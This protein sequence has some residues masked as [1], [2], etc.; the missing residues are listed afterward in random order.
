[1]LHYSLQNF[2]GTVNRKFKGC[3]LEFEGEEHP[4]V[5]ASY[6]SLGNVERALGNYQDAKV[7]HEKCLAIRRRSLGRNPLIATCVLPL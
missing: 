3:M 7:L 5:A 6:H 1:M 4:A 2:L